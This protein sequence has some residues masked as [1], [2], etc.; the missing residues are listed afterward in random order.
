VADVLVNTEGDIVQQLGEQ[1]GTC[2]ALQYHLAH[3]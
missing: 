3:P 2:N 1:Q